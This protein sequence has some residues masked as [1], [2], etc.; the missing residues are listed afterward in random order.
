MDAPRRSDTVNRHPGATHPSATPGTH[1]RPV[2]SRVD[3]TNNSDR[4]SSHT[5]AVHTTA[6][7]NTKPV[8]GKPV[9]G[10]PVGGKPVGGKPVGGKPVG[11]KP[12]GGKPVGGK[13]VGGKPVGGKPGCA[14]L[15][16]GR[17]PNS[18]CC[19]GLS[20]A[21]AD[22]RVGVNCLRV[23]L[24]GRCLLLNRAPGQVR[25]GGRRASG[26]TVARR[27][28]AVPSLGG[29]GP[30]AQG[31]GEADRFLSAPN[32]LPLRRHGRGGRRLRR[33]RPVSWLHSESPVAGRTR[34]W[35][36]VGKPNPLSG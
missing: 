21:V 35:V 12:V 34:L 23:C 9:G 1:L 10:K 19:A 4:T 7:R 24:R 30:G 3:Q 26:A 8:G 33:G 13:P 11:G 2:H 6:I 18:G 5:S 22:L 16:A 29:D 36:R 27:V 32:H 14:G 31:E 28:A 17:C 25:R 20:H 15:A